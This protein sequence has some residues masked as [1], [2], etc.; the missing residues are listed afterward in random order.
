METWDLKNHNK[1]T[2]VDNLPVT[3]KRQWEA[4]FSKTIP[5][6]TSQTS[7]QIATTLTHSLPVVSNQNVDVVTPV[8]N[9]KRKKSVLSPRSLIDQY[10]VPNS[11]REK[12]NTVKEM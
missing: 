3:P 9:K 11:K 5:P 8:S 1:E 7:P 6:L 10:L 4:W 12:L 2:I